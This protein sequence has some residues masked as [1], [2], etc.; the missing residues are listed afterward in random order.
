MRD[1]DFIAL[2]ADTRARTG[3]CTYSDLVEGS[4]R[5]RRWCQSMAARLKAD[6]RLLGSDRAGSLRPPAGHQEVLF[7]LGG[8]G[9]PL[10]R[11]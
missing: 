7:V 10:L 1:E 11:P 4:G 2:V 9:E 3:T 6:G 5:S 8:N